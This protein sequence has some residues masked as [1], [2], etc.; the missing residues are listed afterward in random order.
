MTRQRQKQGVQA[1]NLNTRCW[2]W[3][4]SEGSHFSNISCG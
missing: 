1:W 2:L 3:H 4:I